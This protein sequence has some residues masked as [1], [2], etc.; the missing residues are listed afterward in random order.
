MEEI[1]EKFKLA[2]GALYVRRYFDEDSKKNVVE[3][4]ENLKMS[5]K[6]I[7]TKVGN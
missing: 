5:F 4:I 6:N 1:N 7:I 3:I 2:L